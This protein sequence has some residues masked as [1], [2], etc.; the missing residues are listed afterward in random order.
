MDF[1]NGN[2]G[3]GASLGAKLDGLTLTAD[4]AD[5][6]DRLLGVPESEVAGFSNRRYHDHIGN[7]KFAPIIGGVTTVADG[8][9]TVLRSNPTIGG[10]LTTAE[11]SPT[12]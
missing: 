2:E 12:V 8:S 9:P 1:D 10:V 4:E 3:V 7:L 6:L 5:L 11:G